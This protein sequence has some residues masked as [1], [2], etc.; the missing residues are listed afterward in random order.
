MAGNCHIICPIFLELTH[1]AE[2]LKGRGFVLGWWHCFNLWIYVGT[3]NFQSETSRIR[4]W[5]PFVCKRQRVTFNDLF[6]Y[7]IFCRVGNIV[8]V[9]WPANGNVAKMSAGAD[10]FVFRISLCTGWLLMVVFFVEL[11]TL[12]RLYTLAHLTINLKNGVFES[13]VIVP[14]RTCVHVHYKDERDMKCARRSEVLQISLPTK[15]TTCVR[16]FV[17]KTAQIISHM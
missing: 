2:C 10:L 3:L 8:S 9:C 1:I 6:L 12:F 16:S 13:N 4:I 17:G 14:R 5:I 7:L 15:P 11:A